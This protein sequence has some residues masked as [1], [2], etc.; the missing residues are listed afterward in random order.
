MKGFIAKEVLFCGQIIKMEK[1]VIFYIDLK[2]DLCWLKV[3]NQSN[4]EPRH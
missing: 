4:Y 2:S 3:N 1:G